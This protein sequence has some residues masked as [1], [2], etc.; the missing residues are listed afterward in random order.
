MGELK[1]PLKGIDFEALPWNMNASDKSMMVYVHM[2]K[3]GAE[4]TW[5]EEHY[6]S[7]TDTGA[8]CKALHYGRRRWVRVI[9]T[10]TSCGMIVAI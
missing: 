9:V 3:G 8:V 6:D 5:S 1:P 7:K 4:G 10:R 2:S